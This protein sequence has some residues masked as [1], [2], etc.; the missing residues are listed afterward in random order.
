MKQPLSEPFLTIVQ[1]ADSNKCI[2]DEAALLIAQ[3][4]FKLKDW[5][6]AK[7]K[8]YK[9]S[10]YSSIL[11][12]GNREIKTNRYAWSDGSYVYYVKFGYDPYSNI[13]VYSEKITRVKMN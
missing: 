10:S 5:I 11:K 4:L 8:A 13:V 7:T 12:I 3:H 1:L 2:D 6:N 9:L